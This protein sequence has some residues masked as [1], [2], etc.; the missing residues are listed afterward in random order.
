MNFTIKVC[1]QST[2]T[3]IH[4]GQGCGLVV[5]CMTHMCEVLGSI[6]DTKKEKKGRKSQPKKGS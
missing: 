6:P 1:L 2:Q 4:I 3:K 5:E